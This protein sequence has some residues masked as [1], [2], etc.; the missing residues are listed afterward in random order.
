[1]IV[2][3][4]LTAPGI[5]QPNGTS[6]SR[7]AAASAPSRSRRARPWPGVG[8][9]PGRYRVRCQYAGGT[10]IEPGKARESVRVPGRGPFAKG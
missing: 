7:S 4:E 5:A 9:D 3:F 1:M 2:H 10:L 8:V 6:S